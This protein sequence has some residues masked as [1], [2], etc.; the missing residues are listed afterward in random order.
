MKIKFDFY[1]KDPESRKRFEDLWGNSFL[2]TVKALRM[3]L[4]AGLSP[5]E[6]QLKTV[7]QREWLD[8]KDIGFNTWMTRLDKLEGGADMLQIQCLMFVHSLWF[9]LSKHEPNMAITLH[10]LY[11]ATR[12]TERGGVAEENIMWVKEYGEHRASLI[13]G[14]IAREGISKEMKSVIGEIKRGLSYL[15]T[16]IIFEEGN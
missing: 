11:G 16:D 3:G 12:I 14:D 2:E 4:A 7:L 1:E 5:I 8:V 13:S 10:D 15:D 9:K 6:S